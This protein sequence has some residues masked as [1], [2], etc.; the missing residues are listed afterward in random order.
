MALHSYANQRPVDQTNVQ[1]TKPTSSRP[2]P[3]PGHLILPRQIIAPTPAASKPQLPLQLHIQ[4]TLPNI[5][6]VRP[7]RQPPLL[8]PGIPN[9]QIPPPQRERKHLRR[10]RLQHSLLEP[11]E[12][13]CL[14][15]TWDSHVKLRDFGSR[16]RAR[17]RHGHGD[18]VEGVI[19]RRETS[20]RWARVHGV[21]REGSDVGGRVL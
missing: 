2:N 10:A 6:V 13:L 21:W 12:D 16:K 3:P 7:R 18:G 11:P 5:N 15:A 1:S 4:H 14:A 19:E 20:L 9:T 17:V 8:R